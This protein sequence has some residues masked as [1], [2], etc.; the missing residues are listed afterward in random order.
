L[1]GEET[2]G[3]KPGTKSAGVAR[4]DSGP[5][6]HIA[7]CQI[8]VFLAYASPTGRTWHDRAWSLPQEW[9]AD[10]ERCQGAGMPATLTLQTPPPLAQARLERALAAGVPAPWVTGDAG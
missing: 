3:L 6:G 2:G 5:A 4:Q 10:P 1:I 9:V 7:P 8:G